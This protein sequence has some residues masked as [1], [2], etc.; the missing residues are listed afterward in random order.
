MVRIV[1]A[2]EEHIP[3]IVEV[4]KGFVDL[5]AE[6]DPVFT[7]CREG[8]LTFASW[9]R[10]QIASSEAQVLVALE[11]GDVVGY[12]LT[13]E[14]LYPP[15]YERTTYA[16]VTDMAVSRGHRRHGIGT[17]LLERVRAW[18]QERGLDRIELRMMPTNSMAAA[19]WRKHGFLDYIHVMCRDL[20]AKDGV[21][22]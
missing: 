10:E 19:F 17:R 3:Q 5:H 11:G 13:M 16:E 18:C 2:S 20:D 9:V 22:R 12:A 8:H 15:V 21:G 7:R 14:K 6:R 1:E 4:W